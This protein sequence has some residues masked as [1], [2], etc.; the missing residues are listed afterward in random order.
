MA[1]DA[2]K[3]KKLRKAFA[4]RCNHPSI[5]ILRLAYRALEA[6]VLLASVLVAATAVLIPNQTREVVGVELLVVGVL[7]S[8]VTA[9]SWPSTR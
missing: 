8:R 1:V 9:R 3:N 4:S 2:I 7:V 5:P 6:I